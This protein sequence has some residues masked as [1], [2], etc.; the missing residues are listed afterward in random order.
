[1]FGVRDFLFDV[2]EQMSRLASL[3][4]LQE[5]TLFVDADIRSGV[6]NLTKIS[7][8]FFKVLD[9]PVGSVKQSLLRAMLGTM[10]KNSKSRSVSEGVKSMRSWVGTEKQICVEYFMK[11]R[12]WTSLKNTKRMRFSFLKKK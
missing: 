6:V 10:L 12:F 4:A 9:N 5:A 2:W 7:S 11:H 3:W 8:S 1:V